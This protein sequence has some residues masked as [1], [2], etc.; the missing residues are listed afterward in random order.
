M[1]SGR[2]RIILGALACAGIASA[3]TV[4]YWL[5]APD[6]HAHS[7]LLSATGHSYWPYFVAVAFGCLVASLGASMIDAGR[8]NGTVRA[9]GFTFLYLSILQLVGF[10]GLEAIERLLSGNLSDLLVSPAVLI[11]LALQL[12]VAAIGTAL[13]SG[14]VAVVRLLKDTHDLPNPR[15]SSIPRSFSVAF[16]PALSMSRSGSSWRGPPA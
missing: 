15:S 7:E 3:H 9:V 16:V 1:S 14:L 2:P 12:V 10:A 13:L 8:R 4:A 11:G 6:P 5:V